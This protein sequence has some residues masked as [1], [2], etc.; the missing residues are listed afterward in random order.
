MKKIDV[1]IGIM[2]Y[3]EERN[4]GKLLNILL[5]QRLKTTHI[6]EIVVVS[7]GSTDKTDSIV[8]NAAKKNK[9]N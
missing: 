6:S 5:N 2:A 4:I 8:K 3:N 1:S 9:I 7:S